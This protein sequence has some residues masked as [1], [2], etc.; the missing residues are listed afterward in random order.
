MT[1]QVTELSVLVE[2]ALVLPAPSLAAL[3][4]I[5]ATTVPPVVIPET[6]TV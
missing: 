4:P 3:A 5:E 2:A 1:S 6:L